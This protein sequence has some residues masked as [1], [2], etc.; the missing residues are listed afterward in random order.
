MLWRVAAVIAVAALGAAAAGAGPSPVAA[1]SAC[2]VE[3]WSLKTLSD[4]QRKLVKL[5]PRNTTIAAIDALPMP[6]SAPTTRSTGYERRVWRVRAQIVQFKLEEDSDIHLILF[7]RGHYLIAEM[8][9]GSCLPK[10]TRDRKAIIRARATF[11]GNCGEPTSAWQTLGAVAYISGVGFW[12]FPHGQSGHAPNYA[13][14]HP[15]TAFRI[16][17]GC[18]G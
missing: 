15:V 2:G 16:V 10:T 13:E 17:S 9:L 12:D 6:S 11:I 14:L 18:H 3:L 5:R 4:P 8:P 1:A 7:D